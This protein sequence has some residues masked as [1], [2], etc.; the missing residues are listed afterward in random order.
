MKK[1]VF[2]GICLA[3]VYPAFS[4]ANEA[5][6]YKKFYEVNLH[7]NYPPATELQAQIDA[8]QDYDKGYDYTWNIGK[9]FKTAFRHIIKSYGLSEKRLKTPTEDTILEAVKLMPPSS[10]PYIEY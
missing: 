10:Y 6:K 8:D 1:T 9:K 7:E 2:F 3:L 5:G 4:I